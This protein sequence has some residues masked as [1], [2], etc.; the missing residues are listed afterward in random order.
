MVGGAQAVKLGNG[1]AQ[2]LE[3][4]RQEV[5]KEDAGKENSPSQRASLT[6]TKEHKVQKG[7]RELRMKRRRNTDTIRVSSVFDRWLNVSLPSFGFILNFR[8]GEH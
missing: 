8:R 6:A 1:G 5:G 3:G 4:A 7:W 2:G